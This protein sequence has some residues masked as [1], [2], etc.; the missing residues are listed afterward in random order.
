[1]CSPVCELV[2]D[3]DS[4]QAVKADM[5]DTKAEN[6]FSDFIAVLYSA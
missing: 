6:P 3:N 4:R 5:W 1:M 2:P